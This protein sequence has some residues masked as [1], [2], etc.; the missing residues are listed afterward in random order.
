VLP[1]SD[2]YQPLKGMLRLQLTPSLTHSI[3][4]KDII[5]KDFKIFTLTEENPTKLAKKFDIFKRFIKHK[6]YGEPSPLEQ[7]EQW[8]SKAVKRLKRKREGVSDEENR[9]ENILEDNPELSAWYEELVKQEG[10]GVCDSDEFWQSRGDIL[11]DMEI[12]EKSRIQGMVNSLLSDIDQG[13]FDSKGVKHIQMNNDSKKE[14]FLLYPAVKKEF[15]EQVPAY[16]TEDVFWGRYFQSQHA[17]QSTINLDGITSLDLA[18]QQQHKKKIISK[19]A[20]PSVYVSPFVTMDVDL[21]SSAADH[22]PREALDPDDYKWIAS[23][24]ITQKYIN[25]SSLIIQQSDHQ[26]DSNKNKIMVGMYRVPSRKR[27]YPVQ[28]CHDGDSTL[29][30]NISDD[31]YMIPLKLAAGLSRRT[32]QDQKL[33]LKMNDAVRELL[34]PRQNASSGTSFSSLVFP[35]NEQALEYLRSDLKAATDSDNLNGPNTVA[36]STATKITSSG[37]ANDAQVELPDHFD[38][39]RHVVALYID[40]EVYNYNFIVMNYVEIKKGIPINFR[41]ASLLLLGYKYIS[42]CP[43]E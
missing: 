8:E 24:Y 32:E 25:K 22:Y 35:D 29:L 17:T 20:Q 28:F 2:K 37:C 34:Q 26:Q 16:M 1:G 41:V 7:Q 39:V 21:T 15:D 33:E 18:K 30:N 19:A 13:E 23:D 36:S 5:K 40:S 31:Q 14:I 6:L 27:R 11:R 42:A 43:K 12:D 38:K 4:S 9:I 3:D 10:D